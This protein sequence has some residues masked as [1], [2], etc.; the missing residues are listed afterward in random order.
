MGVMLVA[1]PE[2]Y[3]SVGVGIETYQMI[4]EM[5]RL[6]RRNI[7]QQL[8]LLVEREYDRLGLGRKAAPTRVYAGGLSAVIED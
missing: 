2:K 3:K 8:S 1:N 7:S 6:E 4:V 5:S